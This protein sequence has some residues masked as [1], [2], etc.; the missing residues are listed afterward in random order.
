[1]RLKKEPPLAESWLK[2]PFAAIEA[3]CWFAAAVNLAE[4]RSGRSPRR[5]RVKL[6]FLSSWDSSAERFTRAEALEAAAFCAPCWRGTAWFA[7]AKLIAA[8]ARLAKTGCTI[9]TSAVSPRHVS[10]VGGMSGAAGTVR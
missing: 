3:E 8:A 6:I 2:Y 10:P 4:M 9:L 5:P 7:G 1:M